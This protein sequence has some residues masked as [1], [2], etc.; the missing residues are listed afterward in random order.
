M[1]LITENADKF[2]VQSENYALVCFS[3]GGQL[4]GLFANREIG[5]GN[6][7]VP[8]PGVLLLSYPFVD[9]TYGKLAYHVLIDPGTREWR[10][11][12]TI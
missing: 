8:K 11:Y 5:Y 7:P 4:G 6:Y 10:Y 3:A 9:F 1:Q 2:Q 12:T